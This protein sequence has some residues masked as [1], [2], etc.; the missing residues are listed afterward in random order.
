MHVIKYDRPSG[1]YGGIHEYVHRIGCTARIGNIGMATSFYNDRNEDIADAL[2]KLLVETKQDI[3][4]F[5]EGYKPQDGEDL[6]FD[7][8]SNDLASFWAAARAPSGPSLH[9]PPMGKSPAF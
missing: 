4:D 7:D 2:T 3:P 8:D 1:D 5:L 6:A 9:F